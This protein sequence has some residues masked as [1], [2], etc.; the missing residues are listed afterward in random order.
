MAGR[1]KVYDLDPAMR[2]ELDRLLRDRRWTLDQIVEHLAGL[3]EGPVPS[4][5]SIGRYKQDIDQVAEQMT[6]QREIASAI[7]SKFGDQP[8]NQVARLNLEL[9]H[10]VLF[11]IVTSVGEDGDT[12][13]LSAKEAQLLADAANRLA[14]AEKTNEERTVKLKAEMAKQALAAVDRVAKREGG[15][16]RATVDTIKAE[17]LGVGA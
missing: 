13:S 7:V 16:S 2:A 5:S 3:T 1:S 15:L 9:L 10:G 17:I 14:S 6:R 12:V 4:R 11:R 8:D